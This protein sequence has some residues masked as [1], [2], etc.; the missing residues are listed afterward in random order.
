[1]DRCTAGSRIGVGGVAGDVPADVFAGTNSV[2]ARLKVSVYLCFA[3]FC[4]YGSKVL[5]A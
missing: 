5:G 4:L 3:S 1:M 2:A